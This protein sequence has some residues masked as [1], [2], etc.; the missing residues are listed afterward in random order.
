V[1]VAVILVGMVEVA[2]DQVVGVVTVW[3][4]LVSA[5]GPVLVRAFVDAAVMVWG[6]P[7]GIGVADRDGVFVDVVLVRVMQVPLMEV[8][9]VPLVLNRGMTAIGSV[10]VIVVALVGPVLDLVHRDR[11]SSRVPEHPG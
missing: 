9:D 6:T 1:V 10:D 3:H 2:L 4:R 7:L 8:V 11:S 5:I